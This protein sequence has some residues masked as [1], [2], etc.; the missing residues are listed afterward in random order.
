MPARR[1]GRD[2]PNRSSEKPSYLHSQIRLPEEN[3]FYLFSKIPDD[4]FFHLRLFIE[5]ICRNYR[6]CSF[7]NRMNIFPSTKSVFCTVLQGAKE[8]IPQDDSFTP[9]SLKTTSTSFSFT[10]LTAEAIRFFLRLIFLRRKER[11]I[12]TITTKSNTN[13]DSSAM[14]VRYKETAPTIIQYRYSN[15]VCFASLAMTLPCKSGDEFFYRLYTLP[16]LPCFSSIKKGTAK[17]RSLLLK[18]SMRLLLTRDEPCWRMDP[19]DPDPLRTLR[20][21]HLSMLHN[22][23]QLEFPN[24]GRTDLYCHL[25]E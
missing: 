15:R 4:L 20:P 16:S 1:E 7:A 18:L 6:P 19:S 8:T 22:H 5:C 17:R 23:R 14:I 13:M 2:N 21:G 3:N 11:L 25:L 9:S 10:R 24:D 12:A